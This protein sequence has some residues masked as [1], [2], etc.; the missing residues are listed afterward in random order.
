MEK[1]GIKGVELKWF[2]SYLTDRTQCTKFGAATSTN[3]P[4]RIG[5][6][7]GSKLASELFILYVND[8][9]KSLVHSKLSLFA[10]DTLIY[11]SGK[12]VQDVVNKLNEDL[13]RVNSWLNANKLKLNVA[14]TKYM[15]I[16]N[17]KKSDMDDICVSIAGSE[18][19][20]VS[21]YKYLGMMIDNRLNMKAHIEYA[22]KKIAK[23]VGFLARIS[24]R[25]PMQHRILL[26]KSIIAPHF[27]YCPSV[28]FTCDENQIAKLQKLQNRA[29]RV[30][31]RC[32]RSTS[33]ELMADAL[34]LMTVKQR[35]VFQTMLMV[36][37]IKHQMVPKCMHRNV[38]YVR[39]TNGYPLRNANDFRLTKVKKKINRKNNVLQRV[40]N[41]Q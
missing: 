12:N 16:N 15:V 14:K 10:D 29:M 8:I 26:Y 6:P 33:I 30:I 11:I 5:V 21:V 7:Q 31:L 9:Y 13:S 24:R 18:I 25:L 35:L 40:K 3:L 4:S 27:E 32:K 17:R 28:L 41:V 34:C 22:S 20:Q 19:D 37:R 23:K 1:Y 2:E 39:E 36:F 38:S